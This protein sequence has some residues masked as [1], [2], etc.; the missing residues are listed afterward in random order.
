M[1]HVLTSLSEIFTGELYFTNTIQ[2]AQNTKERVLSHFKM[3]T[4]LKTAALV[5]VETQLV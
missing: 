1:E 3:K 2:N 5:Q 4:G